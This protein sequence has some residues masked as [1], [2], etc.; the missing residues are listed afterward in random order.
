MTIKDGVYKCC[1][2]LLGKVADTGWINL[3]LADGITSY[4]S[5]STPQY[6]KK[7]N[8]IFLRGAFK[9]IDSAETNKTIGVLPEEF[10]P[11]KG[12]PYV[13]N[14]STKNG[15]NFVRYNIRSDGQIIMQQNS[16]PFEQG[17]T[18]LWYPIDTNFLN[19]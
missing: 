8:Q 13:Q 16:Y 15:P 7:G 14:M 18:N 6:R 9:G 12:Y 19:D 1:E 2:F 10:R 3:P 4:N 17:A 11:P 5:D